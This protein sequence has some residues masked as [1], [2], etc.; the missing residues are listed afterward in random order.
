MWWKCNDEMM[1]EYREMVRAKYKEL[2][3]EKG[4][5]EGELRQYTDAFVWVAEE[6][7]GRTS[8]KS[9]YT[10]KQKP[11]MVDGRGGEDSRGEAG[12]MEADSRH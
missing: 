12:S 11:R 5:V 3:A 4:T 7:C 8:G 2:D 10:E 6:L 1:A 9:R